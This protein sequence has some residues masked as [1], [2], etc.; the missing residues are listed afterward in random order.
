MRRLV[1][2]LALGLGITACPPAGRYAVVAED[3][4]CSRATRVA[5]RTMVS[6]GYDVD[7]LTEA[8]PGRRGRVSGTRPRA[9]GTRE[10]GSV[11]ISCKDDK[12]ILQPVEGALVPSSWDFSRSFGY[13]FTSLESRPDQETPQEEIGLQILLETLSEAAATL[14]LGAPAVTAEAVLLRITVRNHTPRPLDLDAKR[15]TLSSPDGDPVAALAGGAL[16]RVMLAGAGADRVRANLLGRTHVP[17]NE[18]V[19]RFL[20]FAPGVYREAHVAIVDTETGETEGFLV[21]VR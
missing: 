14:D 13:G 11:N 1:W 5:H 6:M 4:P 20:V 2:L 18:T 10:R 9:D 16:A 8:A 15:F 21:Q 7:E 3:L 17:A 19:V 12:V